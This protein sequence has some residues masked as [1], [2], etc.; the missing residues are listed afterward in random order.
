M[1][2]LWNVSSDAVA[3]GIF[4]LLISGSGARAESIPL[5]AASAAQPG[6][7]AVAVEETGGQVQDEGTYNPGNFLR[8]MV[9]HRRLAITCDDVL[10][11]SPAAKTQT[12]EDYFTILKQPSPDRA[13][14][15]LERTLYLL[16]RSQGA[17]ICQDKL[18]VSYRA[19]V[20]AAADYNENKPEEWPSAPKIGS[21][22]WCSTRSCEEL[23]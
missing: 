9:Y 7:V 16:V 3:A 21:G 19:Y 15:P 12:I 13:I 4:L 22:P 17:S 14:A 20:R 11:N 6:I 18:D 8:I 2:S 23:K 5:S 10:P 1:K